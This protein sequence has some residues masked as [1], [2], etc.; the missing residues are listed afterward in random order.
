[1]AECLALSAGAPHHAGSRSQQVSQEH[2]KKPDICSNQDIFK[3]SAELVMVLSD[4]TPWPCACAR[5][6]HN[7]QGCH[8]SHLEGSQSPWSL[9]DVFN[10]TE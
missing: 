7:I 3:R 1:M 9:Q 5:N 8:H 10:Y 2:P 6:E 4:M